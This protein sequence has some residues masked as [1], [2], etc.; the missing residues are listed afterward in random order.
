M[1]LAGFQNENGQ[2]VLTVEYLSAWITPWRRPWPYRPFPVPCLRLQM[3]RRLHAGRP[4][5]L[6]QGRI[7]PLTRQAR[8]LHRLLTW[9][10]LQSN[11]LL[12][13]RFPCAVSWHGLQPLALF[14]FL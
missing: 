8:L 7:R 13:L 12:R 5:R 11:L 1:A 6:R 14:G 4:R 9:P 3:Q 2:E 10:L